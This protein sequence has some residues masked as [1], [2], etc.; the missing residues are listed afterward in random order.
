LEK[1]LESCG[2]DHLISKA[3]RPVQTDYIP[4][5]SVELVRELWANQKGDRQMII[6]E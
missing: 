2:H 1:W 4:A 5:E 6:G 3:M